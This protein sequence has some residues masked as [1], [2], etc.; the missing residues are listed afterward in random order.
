M[1]DGVA[2]LSAAAQVNGAA[3]TISILFIFLAMLF[4]VIQKK[5]HLTGA[6]EAAVG[7]VC[8]LA[9]LGIGMMFPLIGGNNA[10]DRI[11]VCLHLFCV[12]AAD[13]ASLK[14]PR[15]YMTTFMFAGMIIGA[16][17]GIV[18]AHPSMNLPAYTGFNN[19]SLGNLF[20]I[21]FVTVACGAVSGFH[22]LVSS[23]T[24][25]KT[26]ANEKDMLKS[27]MARWF[28]KVF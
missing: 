13:V 22:S 15:D 3:G 8:T 9:A 17:V 25:S 6:V 14:Q 16:V 10:L 2:E 20:P 28:W 1:T 24:S 4:G 11:Y 26:V 23:G 27:D 19:A 5:F 7:L 21:L 18:V 12:G